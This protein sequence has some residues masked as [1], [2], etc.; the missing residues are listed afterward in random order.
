[1]KLTFFILTFI[2]GIFHL[3]YFIRPVLLGNRSFTPL[4]VDYMAK[5]I[6]MILL[7]IV[8]IFGSFV[9]RS[10]FIPIIWL[11]FFTII[12]SQFFRKWAKAHPYFLPGFNS[13]L[14]MFSFI[15]AIVELLCH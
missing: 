13:L 3:I 7:P 9:I 6:S 15:I 12:I 4:K 2:L 1:M 8:P 10:Y 11:P 14:I 5:Y